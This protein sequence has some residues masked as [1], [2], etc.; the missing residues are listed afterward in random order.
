MLNVKDELEQQ[1]KAVGLEL[2]FD[3]N[4]VCSLV[5]ENRF[6]VSL[7]YD[8]VNSKLHICA[9]IAPIPEK[10]EERLQT[11]SVLLEANSFGN[12][13]GEAYFSINQQL[14][15][16]LLIQSLSS[17]TFTVQT[18]LEALDR[19]TEVLRYW[20]TKLSGNFNDLDQIIAKIPS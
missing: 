13:T 10:P 11:F 18:F 14:N 16:I 1:F 3:A 8:E 20:A 7:E 19:F 15:E 4:N 12:G 5:V 9:V 2:S 17:L 6:D